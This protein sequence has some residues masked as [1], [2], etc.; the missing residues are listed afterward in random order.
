MVL[1]AVMHLCFILDIVS[2][3][4]VCIKLRKIKRIV[5]SAYGEMKS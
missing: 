5:S 1:H 2:A 4:I 3:I